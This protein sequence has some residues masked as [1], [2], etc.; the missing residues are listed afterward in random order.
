MQYGLLQT[1]P[2]RHRGRSFARHAGDAPAVAVDGVS[3]RYEEQI[4]LENVSFRIDAGERLAVVGPNGAG[5]STL[6]RVLVGLLTPTSGTVRIHGHGPCRHVCISYIPQKSTIDWRFPVTVSDVVR[7]G[8]IARRGPARRMT[9]HGRSLV[10]E[11]LRVVALEPFQHRRIEELS[12]GQQ[13]RMFIA[14]AL[15]QEAEILLMDEPFTGL[16]VNARD[17]VLRQIVRL[18]ERGVTCLVALH[19]LA[20]ASTSFDKVLLLKRQ[21]I[22]FGNPANVFSEQ[23]LQRAYGNCLR[24]T[25]GNGGLVFLHDSACTGGNDAHH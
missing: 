24:L 1:A 8:Q 17:D 4:A 20:I 21:Q 25:G 12:G 15:A 3:V 7:M 9:R 23:G 2:N 16:D 19:D 11:A 6:L 13:Q 14:R 10:Q 5:K 22:G 18:H